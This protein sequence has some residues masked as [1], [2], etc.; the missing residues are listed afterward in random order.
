MKHE[1]ITFVSFI[2]LSSVNDRNRYRFF[3]VIIL[4]G[5]HYSEL[6][7]STMVKALTEKSGCLDTCLDHI[8]SF[9]LCAQRKKFKNIYI[10]EIFYESTSTDWS[11]L[12]PNFI[13]LG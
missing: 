9:L 5:K 3:Y 13:Y 1:T 4:S 12:T 7:S 10:R 11:P 2:S 6:N 8:F